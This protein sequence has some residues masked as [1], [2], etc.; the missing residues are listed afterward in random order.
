MPYLLTISTLGWTYRG[1]VETMLAAFDIGQ[2][3]YL[4]KLPSQQHRY[5]HRLACCAVFDLVAAAGAVCHHNCIRL[6][7]H[8]G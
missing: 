2:L 6:L 5:M 8:C 3:P 4:P 1:I 7:A